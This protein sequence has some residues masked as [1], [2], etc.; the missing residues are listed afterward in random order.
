MPDP[1]Y[2]GGDPPGVIGLVVGFVVVFFL[3]L[4]FKSCM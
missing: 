2:A 1:D 3:L 4:T